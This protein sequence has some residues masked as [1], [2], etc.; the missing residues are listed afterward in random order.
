M[1]NAK[2]SFLFLSLSTALALCPTKLLSPLAASEGESSPF[3]FEGLKGKSSYVDASNGEKGY[4]LY[5]YDEGAKAKFLSPQTGVFEAHLKNLSNSLKTYTLN[6]QDLDSPQSFDVGVNVY[7]DHLEFYGAYGEEKA[8][9][10]THQN[11]NKS[12][13]TMGLTAAYNEVGSYSKVMGSDAYLMVDPSSLSIKVRGDD[14][15][16]KSVWDFSKEFNDGKR[17]QN[18]LMPFAN[19]EVSVSFLS[20]QKF[21]KS[22]LLVFEFG[23]RKLDSDAFSPEPLLLAKVNQNAVVGEAY[24]LPEPS[25]Y[26]AKGTTRDVQVK[27]TDS[28]GN[29]IPVRDNSFTPS[30]AGNYYLIYSYSFEGE[31]AS[32]IQKIAALKERGDISWNFVEELPLQQ[33]LGLHSSLHV[34]KATCSGPALISSLPVSCYVSIKKDGS[35]LDDFRYVNAGF[36]YEFSSEGEYEIIY[37]S[38]KD[39]AS[40]S[41]SFF[42]KVSKDV[43]GFNL[44]NLPKSFNL[45][46]T[47]SVTPVSFYYQGEVEEVLPSLFLPNGNEIKVGSLVLN[48]PGTYALLYRYH[49]GETIKTHKETF[50]VYHESTSMFSGSSSIAHAT[51]PVNNSYQG[52]EVNLGSNDTLLYEKTIDLSRYN[53]DTSLDDKTQNPLLFEAFS[54]PNKIGRRGIGALYLTLTDE[55]NP[56]NKLE[57]RVKQVNYYDHSLIRCRATDQVWTGYHYDFNTAAIRVDKIQAHEEGGFESSF[58]FTQADASRRNDFHFNALR[59]YFDYK[60]KCLYSTPRFVGGAKDPA[61]LKMPWLVRDLGTSDKTLSGGDTPW[62]GFASGKAKLSIYAVG[63]AM[64]QYLI[65]NVDGQSFASESIHDKNGPTFEFEDDVSS[66]PKG[67]VGK[68]YP[69]PKAQ[70]KDGMSNVLSSSQTVYFGNDLLYSGSYFVP[71]KAG[72]YTI[73]YLAKDS[74][75]NESSKTIDVT[76][77]DALEPLSLRLEKELPSSFYMGEEVTLPDAIVEGGAGAIKIKKKVLFGKDEIALMGNSFAADRKG[78]YKVLYEASDYIGNTVS[79]EFSFETIRSESPAFEESRILL[80]ESFIDGDSFEFA[81]YVSS[82]FDASFKK[83]EVRVKIEVT[84]A[85]GTRFLEDDLRYSPKSSDSI[86]EAKIRFVF[87]AKDGA[88]KEIVRLVPIEKI[89]NGYGFMKHYFSFDSLESEIGE[90][91]L[92]VSLMEGKKNGSLNFKRPL[93]ANM[94]RLNFVLGTFHQGIVYLRDSQDENVV[95]KLAFS[96]N[97]DSSLLVS[98]NDGP[99]K[100]ANTE[101]DIL[102]LS[103]KASTRSFSDSKGVAF[104]TPTTTL[105]GE[106]F[107]GF[108]SG[109]VYLEF[110]FE[111]DGGAYASLKAINNMQVN[112]FSSDRVGPELYVNGNCSGRFAQGSTITIHSAYGADVLNA[113]K[114]V[115]VRV[116]LGD[117]DV[118][119]SDDASKDATFIATELGTYVVT[120]TLEDSKGN[121]TT[122]R[123]YFT[124]YDSVSPTL[125]WKSEFVKTAKVGETIR[126]PEYTINDNGD[127]SKASVFV[128]VINAEGLMDTIENGEYRFTKK[129]IYTFEYMVLDDAGN[130]TH[131]SFAV[132]VQ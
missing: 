78:T 15:S 64:H 105:S 112:A 86:K 50:D 46:A 98:V 72:T 26:G 44:S 99:T 55:L 3:A 101:A 42:V 74:F 25:L 22:E 132:L 81:P 73:R 62:G 45:G 17:L 108:K 35:F 29:E 18:D 54:I 121:R 41:Q 65:T 6:F 93:L 8:G 7:K 21:K 95:I 9:I 130:R 96:H 19:Y 84:D 109:K 69:I 12:E 75:G 48:E 125:E 77:L 114:G 94:L 131:Y 60:T 33:E 106:S 30:L 82:Y 14:G 70:A 27:V 1:K 10:Y 88:K 31:E 115:K 110:V 68:P 53:F 63:E 116:T 87:E 89:A 127:V 4:L 107:E 71:S 128:S 32:A 124:I 24:N 36:N 37:H 38:A 111:G 122:Q 43:V 59:L 76:V 117:K 104:A 47:Y 123:Q 52:V 102:S 56:N 5:G 85:N 118:Y 16:Y 20:L 90:D 100:L 13:E 83:E 120:Y 92:S 58:S 39:E 113:D 67:Q 40:P 126:L 97:D 129:G 91:G 119:Q 11:S 49:E 80:P 79:K 23:G 57:I 61:N 66:L 34:G 51:L 103:Y 2:V 28:N